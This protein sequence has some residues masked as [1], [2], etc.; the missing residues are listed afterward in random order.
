MST[1]DI[2]TV[3]LRRE[4]MALLQWLLERAMPEIIHGIVSAS[5]GHDDP[6]TLSTRLSR[7]VGN[8]TTIR[9]VLEWRQDD[10][11]RAYRQMNDVGV[12]TL[13][14]VVRAIQPEKLPPVAKMAVE[15]LGPGIEAE[16]QR[17]LAQPVKP[18][19]R[20]VDVN[21]PQAMA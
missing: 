15:R 18:M 16:F 19:W 12:T 3:G 8:Y 21:S 2:F 1:P 13:L 6:Q 14:K 9:L 10:Q 5:W 20:P 4:E 7:V 11:I 17:A